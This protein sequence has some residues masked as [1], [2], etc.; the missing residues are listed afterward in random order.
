MLREMPK[1]PDRATRIVDAAL[2]LAARQG[3]RHVSLAAI[4]AEAR[5]P[6]L[7][8]HAVFRSRGAILDAFHRRIDEA[9]LAG[10]PEADSERPHDRLFDALMRRFEAL[11]PHREAVRFMMR[12]AWSD[13][14]A[15]LADLPALLGSM[16]WMLEVSGIPATG[17]R[18]RLRAK[19]LLGIYLST[20]RAWLADESPDMMKTMAALDHRL[21]NAGRWLG[22]ADA[23]GEAPAPAA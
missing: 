18:G 23:G 1:R 12:D 2:R 8:V 6:V 20:V 14:L 19:V 11:Q 17:W 13:P 4:A 21:R 9:V 22:T 16:A 10:G 5:L 7:E 15:S 3:W